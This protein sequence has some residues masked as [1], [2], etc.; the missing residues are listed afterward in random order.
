MKKFFILLLISSSVLAADGF[1]DII[2]KAITDNPNGFFEDRSSGRKNLPIRK[3]SN[4]RFALEIK[5]SEA[6]G[7]NLVSGLFS[8]LGSVS[9]N[10]RKTDHKKYGEVDFV[11]LDNKGKKH[12]VNC[13]ITQEYECGRISLVGCFS[14][15]GAIVGPSGPDHNFRFIYDEELASDEQCYPQIVHDRRQ[16]RKAIK[17]K[18]RIENSKGKETSTTK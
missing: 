18:A 13:S 16:R 6:G 12:K 9:E 15:S 17:E 1:E 7:K 8:T 4:G 3:E 10:L 14:K 5:T 2:F 11:F